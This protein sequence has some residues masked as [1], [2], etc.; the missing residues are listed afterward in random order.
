MRTDRSLYRLS[1]INKSRIQADNY[2]AT[3]IAEMY[4]HNILSVSD[5]ESF[6][7]QIME[8]TAQNAELHFHISLDNLPEATAKDLYF[9][10]LYAMDQFLNSLPNLSYAVTALQSTSADTLYR[11]GMQIVSANYYETVSF[12]S[13]LKR[14]MVTASDTSYQHTLPE[15][16]RAIKKIHPLQNAYYPISLP[17][18][19]VALLPR[20][21]NSLTAL[22]HYT[23][24]FLLENEFCCQ[25]DTDDIEDLLIR[26]DIEHKIVNKERNINI[27]MLVL[28]NLMLSPTPLQLCT[29]S[30]MHRQE[31]INELY[32][33]PYAERRSLLVSKAH[34]LSEQYAKNSNE[35]IRYIYKA[36]PYI[37]PQK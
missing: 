16:R 35:L 2:T 5:V 21:K 11:R 33:L 23:K 4:R 1:M 13:K 10:V 18:Y 3:L 24:N 12:I 29:L 7:L 34:I 26:Y 36:I 31:C 17:S 32:A 19:K 6:K 27:F 22:H 30:E 37:F 25:F 28:E 8:I 15:L 20:Q 14:T 9:S